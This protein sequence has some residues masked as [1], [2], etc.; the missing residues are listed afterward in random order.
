MWNCGASRKG[1]LWYIEQ[2]LYQE[3]GNEPKI[4][5]YNWL[6]EQFAVDAAEEISRGNKGV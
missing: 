1:I 6:R 3:R 2:R 5:A 4:V